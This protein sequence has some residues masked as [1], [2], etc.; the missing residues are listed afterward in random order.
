MTALV[1]KGAGKGRGTVSCDK[2]SYGS[3]LDVRWSAARAC[4]A[5]C[6]PF[7]P[8]VIDEVVAVLLP[9]R[10]LRVPRCKRLGVGCNEATSP[11]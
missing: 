3:Q 9:Q 5:R 6:G 7:P 1:R 8:A 11:V 10:G 2:R 4:V